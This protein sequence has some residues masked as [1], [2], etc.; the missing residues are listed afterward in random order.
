VVTGAALVG[1]PLPGLPEIRT[2]DDL[3]SLLADAAA[4]VG[5][6]RAGDVVV[7]A[8]KAV[9]KAEGRV[10]ALGDV[11]P[12][13]RARALGAEHGKDPRLVEL[14][15]RESLELVR[16]DA[17]RLIARTRHGFVCA[18]AGVD[19]S[20]AG[21]EEQ[22]VLLPVDPDGSARALRARLGCAVVI[23]DSFGR[24]WRVGQAEVAIGCAGLA[25][26]EDWRG[27]PDSSGRTLRATNIAVADQA[28][29]AADLVRGKDTSEPAV[30]LRGL[31]RHVLP[32]DGPGAAAL[33][34]AAADDL[35][36]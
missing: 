3:G 28:A 24:A 31:E 18:N 10:G 19:L 4:R 25:P 5:G 20:N 27:R 8:H 1:E 30:R 33:L 7:V 26:L 29:A 22:A 21:G 9:A 16:A 6:L 23:G 13:E 14:I 34:R 35:F 12:G 2:G 15:L 36:A 32:D 17:G 11:E